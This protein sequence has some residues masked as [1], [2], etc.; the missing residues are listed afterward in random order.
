[1]SLGT[2]MVHQCTIE[3]NKQTIKSDYNVNDKPQWL[4][5]ESPVKCRF[6]PQIS[7]VRGMGGIVGEGSPIG[8]RDFVKRVSQFLLP[9]SVTVSEA[10]RITNVL[11]RQGDPIVDGKGPF[12]ILLVRPVTGMAA[13]HTRVIVE[14]VS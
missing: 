10:D 2:M 1:M 5:D 6:M 12:N 4:A 13:S 7:N 3:R 14:K 11:N 8:A 9:R